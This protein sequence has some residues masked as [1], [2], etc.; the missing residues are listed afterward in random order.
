M[1]IP[2]Q[3]STIVSAP[4]S[5]QGSSR[6]RPRTEREVELRIADWFDGQLPGAISAARRRHQERRREQRFEVLVHGT[7]PT[8]PAVNL[9]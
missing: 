2:S 8:D 5:V 7:E 6:V 3:V 4:S 9:L 1:G